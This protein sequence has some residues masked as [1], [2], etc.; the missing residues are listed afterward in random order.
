MDAC[1]IG[2]TGPRGPW[3]GFAAAPDGYRLVVGRDDGSELSRSADAGVL[4]ALAIAY[5]E[6]AF[7]DA[8][9]D[10]EATHADLSAMVRHVAGIDT[11]PELRDVLAEAVDAIDDGL[12]GDA[13][14]S[15][16]GAAWSRTADEQ[17]DPVD[18]LV[19]LSEEMLKA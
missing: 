17:A 13:V 14:A 3:V 16:L 10:R 11:R 1:V 9:V 18:L 5:F 7:E 6:E 2:R 15:R 4:L 12:P 8:P 19:K